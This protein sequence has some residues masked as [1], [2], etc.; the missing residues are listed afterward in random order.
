VAEGESAA[1]LSVR[2]DPRFSVNQGLV[3]IK[4][5]NAAE[6][7]RSPARL[8][9]PLVRRGGALEPASWDE[10]LELVAGRLLELRERRGP[11]AVGAFGSGALTNE[12]V[13]LLSK[14]V[15]VA[16]GSSQLD[17]NGRYCMASAAGGQ[18]RAFGVDRGMPFPLSDVAETDV[19]VLF[20]SNCVDTMPPITQWL[21]ALRAR[22]GRLIV[23]DPRRTETA[24]RADLHLQLTPGSDLLLA[25]GLLAL[26]LEEGLVDH[27][28]VEARTTGLDELRRGLGGFE[29]AAVERGTGVSLKDLRHT[30]YLLARA[31]RSMV[32]SGR[33]PEQ[34]ERGVDTVSALIDLMLLLGKVGKPASGYGTITGQGNGQGGREHGQKADQLPGYRSIT[35]PEARRAVA[36]AWGIEESALPGKGRSAVEMLDAIGS[37]AGLAALLVF[38][39]NLVVASPSARRVRERLGALELLVVCDSFLNETAALADVV[40]PTLQWAEESGTVTNLEGRVLL[41]P[42]VVEPPVGPRSDLEILVALAARLGQG[43]HFPSAEPAVVFDEFARVTAGAL[44]DYSGLSHARLAGGEALYWPCPSP[45]HPGTPRLFTERFAH[46]DGRARLVPVRPRALAEPPDREYPLYFITGRYREHYNSGA[47]TRQVPALVSAR[48]EPL[49][50]LHPT[51]A[52]ELNLG[53]GDSARVESRRGQLVATVKLDP[54]LRRDTVFLPFHFGGAQS[55]NLLTNPVLDPTSRMPEFKV[56][57]VRVSAGADKEAPR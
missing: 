9:S 45:A 4:G 2:G 23:V 40:L 6:L 39:S 43:A 36:A 20:G 33:G 34:Q 41:R 13:Y 29:V 46:P 25:G 38:G 27:A 32:L 42:A 44:A 50:E 54:S 55:A 3:C 14:F 47:Q 31:E 51:L 24:R 12:K 37:P 1:E 8:T 26:T 53:E 16:L 52:A 57:A 22:G 7:L 28:Y 15:R 56:C 5:F 48:P 30:L 19:L 17:Y 21:E 18:N 49:L 10:A 35:D 11:D